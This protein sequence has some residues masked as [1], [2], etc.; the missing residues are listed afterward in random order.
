MTKNKLLTI[1]DINQILLDVNKVLEEA[2]THWIIKKQ[3]GVRVT[4][5]YYIYDEEQGKRLSIDL[6]LAEV[7]ALSQLVSVA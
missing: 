5:E 7:I 3:T 4:H 1:E 6:S 2:N